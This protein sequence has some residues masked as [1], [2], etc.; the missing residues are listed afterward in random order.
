MCTLNAENICLGC[1]R[2]LDEITS[3]TSY[4]EQYREE[5]IERC[6]ERLQILEVQSPLLK[7]AR[8]NQIKKL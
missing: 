2:L 7:E 8:K 6:E 4:S 3:W 5:I 1:G